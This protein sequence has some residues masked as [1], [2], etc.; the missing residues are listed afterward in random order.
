MGS[1]EGEVLPMA[2]DGP[3]AFSGDPAH[4]FLTVDLDVDDPA[5][6]VDGALA[7][8][9]EDDSYLEID[10]A[11]AGWVAAELVAAALG[12]AHPRAPAELLA[13]AKNL[14]VRPKLVKRAQLVLKRIV[15]PECELEEAL[16][17]SEGK[18]R[19]EIDGLQARLS[20]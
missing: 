14:R 9:L 4:D 2:F 16:E 10:A 7:A 13:A 8:V 5:E 17:H 20:G 6:A 18:V 12:R 19:S 15:E 3:D 11:V 1:T